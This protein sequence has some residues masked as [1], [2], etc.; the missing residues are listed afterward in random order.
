MQTNND[1]CLWR[2]VLLS[3]QCICDVGECLRA[4]VN[5][6]AGIWVRVRARKCSACVLIASAVHCCI[7]LR[8][9]GADP[10]HKHSSPSQRGPATASGD[11]AL[12]F[13]RRH[14][15]GYAH[16]HSLHPARHLKHTMPFTVITL[17]S[18]KTCPLPKW[19]SSKVHGPPFKNGKTWEYK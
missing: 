16:C 19:D 10:A 13:S 3:V 6:A 11:A 9:S 4:C 18:I 7:Y 12:S 1:R 2:F 17:E 5:F 8:G 15:S 14:T